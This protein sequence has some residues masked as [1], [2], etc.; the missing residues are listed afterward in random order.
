M[1]LIVLYSTYSLLL[2]EKRKTNLLSESRTTVL[3]ITSYVA[4]DDYQ[5][6]AKHW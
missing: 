2:N 4:D 5:M 1:Y 6:N 3:Y